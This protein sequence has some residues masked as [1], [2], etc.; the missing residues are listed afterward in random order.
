MAKKVIIDIEFAV[1]GTGA[2]T[3]D[4]TEQV[5][6][7]ISG[8]DLTVSARKFGIENPAPGETKHFAVKANITIDDNEPYPFFYIAKD[9]ETID[10]IP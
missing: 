4:V 6:N 10:F 5:Q 7:T 2:N 8:D 3:V 1:Y 9:Y